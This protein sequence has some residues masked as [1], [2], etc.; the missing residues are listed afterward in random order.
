MPSFQATQKNITLWMV[1]GIFILA[2]SVLL[3][4]Y[5][6]QVNFDGISYLSIA[7]K[8]MIG[9]FKNAINGFWSP[10]YVWLL[11]P[12]YW[13][14][15]DHLIASKVL[16]LAIGAVS[17]IGIKQ[18]ADRFSISSDVRLAVLITLIPHIL[19]YS[20][21]L[22]GPDVL[23]ACIL[24]F[25]CNTLLAPDYAQR[26]RYGI[27]CGILGGLAYL[28]KSFCLPFFIVHYPLIN[29]FLYLSAG[30]SVNKKGV[31]INFL[32]G[33]VLFMIISAPWIFLISAKYDHFTFSEKGTANI[34]LLNVEQ[35]KSLPKFVPPPDQYA[36]SVWDDPSHFFSTYYD[37]WNPLGSIGNIKI[38]AK[39]FI[40]NCYKLLGICFDASILF[41]IFLVGTLVCLFWKPRFLLSQ[42]KILSVLL[43]MLI[44]VAG[45]CMVYVELRYFIIVSILVVIICGYALNALFLKYSLFSRL[46]YGLLLLLIISFWVQPIQ[47]LKKT[48]NVGKDVF[49]LANSLKNVVKPQSRIVNNADYIKGVF[50]AYHLNCSI[51]GASENMSIDELG[52]QL[53]KYKIDYFI[54]LN[55]SDNL[56]SSVSS[57]ELAGSSSYQ[58]KKVLVYSRR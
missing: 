53:D 58:D 38:S 49:T 44:Y 20:L 33:T 16:N 21:C 2:G 51:Y 22:I 28:S 26:S 54:T 40:F 52:A 57:Y 24:I 37:A 36:V 47:Q 5:R 45:Y 7:Q 56:I 55:A 41:V 27:L 48:V 14:N 4:W 11:L 12:F 3:P 29:L 43:L 19:L 17:F 15:F 31:M 6:F 34:L 13:L 30:S 23:T 50:L 18:L 10:L 1:F 35:P 25:Y 9:D 32:W 8:Y 42:K 46:K 39:N